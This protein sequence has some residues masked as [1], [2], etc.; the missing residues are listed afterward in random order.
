MHHLFFANGRFFDI[1]VCPH[2]NNTFFSSHNATLCLY[3]FNG[4]FVT[5][6]VLKVYP[7]NENITEKEN[8]ISN[9]IML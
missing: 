8:N 6:I 5:F 3:F 4:C 1:L 7:N 2:Y 9:N